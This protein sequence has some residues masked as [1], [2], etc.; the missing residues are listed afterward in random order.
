MGNYGCGGS[1]LGESRRGALDDG[2]SPGSARCSSA[3]GAVPSGK[4]VEARCNANR[5]ARVALGRGPS[6][7]N[8]RL[9][10]GRVGG[11]RV[12]GEGHGQAIGLG[13]C[14]RWETLGAS[15]RESRL[16]SFS[17]NLYLI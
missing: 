12:Q 8:F 17:Y 6:V 2:R 4:R 15:G 14:A 1:S 7:L 11:C 9:I 5:G 16:H 3:R 10:I 13:T